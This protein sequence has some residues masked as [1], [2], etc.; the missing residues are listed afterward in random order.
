MDIFNRYLSLWAALCIISGVVLG[1][2]APEVFAK[3]ASFEF[4]H[5]NLVVAVLIWIM[6]YPMMVQSKRKLNHTL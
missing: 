1:N 4:A 6:I 3:I 2:V 5:V